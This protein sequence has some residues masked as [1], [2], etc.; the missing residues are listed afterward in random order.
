MSDVIN[1]FQ[2]FAQGFGTGQGIRQSIAQSDLQD[3]QLQ[4]AQQ[5]AI[6][7]QEQTANLNNL[8]GVLQSGNATPQDYVNLWDALPPEQAKSAR[9]SFAVLTEAE[10][11][12]SLKQLG[13]VYSSFNAGSPEIAI[14]LMEDLKQAYVNDGKNEEA[15]LMNMYI[16]LA[17]E[18]ELGEKTAETFFGSTMALIPGGKDYM[19]SVLKSSVGRDLTK[20]Q[21][22]KLTAETAKIVNELE[23]L[24]KTGG[25]DSKTLFD[26]EE[27]LRKEYIGR[28]KDYTAAKTTLSNMEAS[29]LAE[30]GAGDVALVTGFMKMLDPGS[31]V[32]ETEFATAR[33]TAGTYGMLQTILPKVKEG[34][35]LTPL[36]RKNFVGLARE[37]MKS[38]DKHEAGVKRDLMNVVNS[39]ELDVNNVFGGDGTLTPLQEFIK[40]NNPSVK[41]VENMSEEEIK[42][43]FP[44]GYNTYTGNSSQ[45]IEPKIIRGL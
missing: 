33:N 9:E 12:N 45:A 14:S 19:E 5:Q 29:A 30:S 13:D 40:K 36:Q 44:N 42:T 16:N 38:A 37:Y 43:S 39:Y 26:Q 34:I 41:G 10:Q 17:K 35:L 3:F 21:T 28:V 25:I 2:S 1:P 27:K 11:R 6:A 4:Q 15:K 20:A 32:R 22:G 23:T 8:Y 24:K 18:G 31:V 7:Q